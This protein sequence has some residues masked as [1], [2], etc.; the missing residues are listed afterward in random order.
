VAKS[1]FDGAATDAIGAASW[2]KLAVDGAFIALRPITSGETQGQR[3][4]QSA[5]P[6]GLNLPKTGFSAKTGLRD[7]KNRF[8]EQSFNST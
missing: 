1:I 2:C 7:D 4:N 5:F 8:F 3:E 6:H